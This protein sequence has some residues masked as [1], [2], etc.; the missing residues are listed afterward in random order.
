MDREEVLSIA[1]REMAQQ[2]SH[3][4]REPGWVLR[5][6]MGTARLALE[7]RK[8]LL[9]GEEEIDDILYAAALFHDCGKFADEH[10]GHA[11]AGAK[12]ARELLE[13]VVQPEQLDVICHAILVHDKRKAQAYTQLEYILQ[14]A[15]ILDHMG[16]IE[17]WLNF[18]YSARTN[19]GAAFSA[20]YYE[21]REFLGEVEMNRS[22]LNYSQSVIAFQEKLE[23]TMMFIERFRRECEGR[24]DYLVPR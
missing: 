17:I 11:E 10:K 7:L 8:T 21:S 23:F 13:G 6:G 15:D 14:D 5:H 19:R 1:R 12:R 16:S 18:S 22:L 20:D 2:I 3:H 24:L 9:D 4:E